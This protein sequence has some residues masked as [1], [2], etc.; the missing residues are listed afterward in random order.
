VLPQIAPHAPKASHGPAP[1]GE[2]DSGVALTFDV[3]HEV[4][5]IPQIPEA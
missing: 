1:S 3:Y 4:P 2:E 5:G